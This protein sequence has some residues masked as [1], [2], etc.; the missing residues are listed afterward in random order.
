MVLQAKGNCL[1]QGEA[2]TVS[3]KDSGPA[4]LPRPGVQVSPGLQAAAGAPRRRVLVDRLVRAAA[5]MTSCSRDFPGGSLEE[6]RVA[7]SKYFRHLSWPCARVRA[8]TRVRAQARDQAPA[9]SLQALGRRPIST[10]Q[11]RL[12]S[13]RSPGTSGNMAWAGVS[14]KSELSATWALFHSDF[15]RAWSWTGV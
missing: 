13:P 8:R 5:A 12:Q 10:P 14:P 2:T 1:P 15:F 7:S 6:T 4:S 11:L 3:W 9:P